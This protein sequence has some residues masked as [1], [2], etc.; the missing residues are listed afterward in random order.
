MQCIAVTLTVCRRFCA[1]GWHPK[2]H[3]TWGPADGQYN[4]PGQNGWKV[5]P[6]TAMA[7]PAAAMALPATAKPLPFQA[8]VPYLPANA[9]PGTAAALPGT[10]AALPAGR[11]LAN[12][13]L[14][15]APAW[16]AGA[17]ARVPGVQLTLLG[18]AKRPRRG[19]QV[20]CLRWWVRMCAGYPMEEVPKIDR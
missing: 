16:D 13:M 17:L 8:K 3:T 19:L 14:P 9:L 7:L 4:G 10:A 15:A 20:T 1:P 5:L 12:S 18:G 2:G 11:H 6:G